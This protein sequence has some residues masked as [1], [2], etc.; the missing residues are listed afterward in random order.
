VRR[1]RPWRL[2]DAA[3]RRSAKAWSA[4]AANPRDGGREPA[5]ERQARRDEDRERDAEDDQIQVAQDPH[6]HAGVRCS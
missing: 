5:E 3:A 4:R 1:A 6:A 2:P